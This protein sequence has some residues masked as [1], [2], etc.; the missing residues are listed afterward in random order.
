MN[1]LGNSMTN[2]VY[3]HNS[4]IY[5]YFGKNSDLLIDR[6]LE[7][8]ILL[9]A[10]KHQLAPKILGEFNGGR[11]EEY[12]GTSKTLCPADML[13]EKYLKPIATR[14]AAFHQ[15]LIPDTPKTSI[16][17]QRITDWAKLANMNIP[18]KLFDNVPMDTVILAHN[19]LI[20]FN[21]LY[22]K[23][24]IYFIDLEYAGYNYLEFD[25][26]NMFCEMRIDQDQLTFNYNKQIDELEQ[27]FCIWYCGSENKGKTLYLRVQKYKPVVH[28]LW[29]VW[30]K[31]KG[32]PEYSQFRYSLYC[33]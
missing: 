27:K 15:L 14:L 33:E 8:K 7:R 29:F 6:E 13:N 16:L 31:I 1:K 24:D 20:A 18:D 10:G 26:A 9:I 17:K 30:G 5:R 25:I 19:D 21:I 28:W 12:L 22:Y 23:E 11:V 4:K 32:Y 2:D 3:L